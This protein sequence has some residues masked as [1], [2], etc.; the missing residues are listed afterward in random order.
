MKILAV[1]V[2]VCASAVGGCAEKTAPPAV[3]PMPALVEAAPAPVV[4]GT[5]GEETVSAAATVEGVDQKT[6]HVTL[7]RAD[8]TKFEIV[9]GPEVRNLAQLRKG[10]RVRVEYRQSVAYEVKR[11]RGATPGVSATSGVSRAAPGEKPG[12][13]ATNAVTVRMKITAIDKG[14]SEA[15][16]LGPHGN[17]TV[18]K[19]RDP[20]KLDAVQVGDVVDVTYTEAMAVSVDKGGRR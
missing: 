7:K 11:S 16:L 6:R 9:A 1:V 2:V 3:E 12:G 15:T 5:L 13:T 8:G 17:V 19:A 4:S 18:V 20:S 10:D 14:A